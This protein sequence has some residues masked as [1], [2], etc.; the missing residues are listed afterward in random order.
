MTEIEEIDPFLKDLKRLRKQYRSIDEDLDIF[1]QALLVRLPNRLPD[2]FRIPLGEE[3]QTDPVFK[4]K[5]FRCK[6]L[7][8]GGRSGIRIIYGYDE[9]MDQITLIEI[10]HKN[11]KENH[12]NDRL[13]AFLKSKRDQ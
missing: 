13:L 10:Y 5:S 6:S 8:G 4:V 12:D 3:F 1:I 2:T 11:E 9:P 7:G